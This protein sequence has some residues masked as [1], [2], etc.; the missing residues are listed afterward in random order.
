MSMCPVCG[1]AGYICAECDQPDGECECA[2]GPTLVRCPESCTDD[3][4]EDDDDA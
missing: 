3:D 4:D 2:D 1:D